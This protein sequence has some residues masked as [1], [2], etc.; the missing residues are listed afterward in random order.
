MPAHSACTRLLHDTAMHIATHSAPNCNSLR[1]RQSRGIRHGSR[2]PHI[3]HALIYYMTPHRTLQHTL[4]CT[5]MHCGVAKVKAPPWVSVP[6]HSARACLL[7]D[8]APYTASHAAPN[9]NSL[10]CRRSRCTCHGF[11][12]CT[13]HTR[14]VIT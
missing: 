9:C 3:P 6:A 1:C 5:V 7:H 10:R 4:H 12:A 2:C 11:R 14:S 8:T 13:F